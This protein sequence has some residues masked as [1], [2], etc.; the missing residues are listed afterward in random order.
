M[1]PSKSEEEIEREKREKREKRILEAPSFIDRQMRLA[2]VPSKFIGKG[3]LLSEKFEDFKTEFL[4]GLP[5]G[6]F[7]SGNAGVG[8]TTMACRTLEE[9]LRWIYIE[10]Y[11]WGSEINFINYPR[12]IMSLQ[13]MYRKDKNEQS[14]FDYLEEISKSDLLV[15][16][17][18]GAEKL[19][20]FV[21]QCT[22]FLINEREMYERSTI[23]T[24]NYSLEKLADQIDDRIASR[25]SGMCKTLNFK[26][27]DKRVKNNPSENRTD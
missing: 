23:I 18:L 25:I 17:D 20:D 4:N 16:D 2:G 12:F 26:G 14:V 9:I 1:K 24:S 6:L 27:R 19:T 8:K 15:I 3:Y 13:D 5:C 11:R 7:L 10:C 22:Y 21:R